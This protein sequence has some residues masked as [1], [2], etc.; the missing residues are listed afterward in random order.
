MNHNDLGEESLLR[1]VSANSTLRSPRANRLT[2]F[3]ARSQRIPVLVQL[4]PCIR[5][6]GPL[7]PAPATSLGAAEAGERWEGFWCVADERFYTRCTSA[8]GRER[9]Y[10]IADLS[11]E[12]RPTRRGSAR[13]LAF[14][15]HAAARPRMLVGRY[16]GQ[17]MLVGTSARR[18]ALKVER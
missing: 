17:A 8:A 10:R 4:V 6:D 16:R 11:G 14:P 13:V 12:A 2:E 18:G 15:V 3:T 7:E 9:W 5:P 1:A